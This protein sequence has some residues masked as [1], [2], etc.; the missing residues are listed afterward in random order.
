MRNRTP[1]ETLKGPDIWRRQPHETSLSYSYFRHYRDQGETRTLRRTAKELGRNET[2]VQDRARRWRWAQRADADDLHM[3]EVALA[4][5]REEVRS[6]S[7]R[8]ARLGLE[9]LSL[10]LARITG[11]DTRNIQA[12]DPNKLTPQDLAR[13]TEVMSKLERLSRGAES[14]RVEQTGQ[15]AQIRLAFN[16][17]PDLHGVKMDGFAGPS[18]D[19]L[20]PLSEN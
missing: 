6:M 9:T 12:I 18:L 7:Q 10:V 3:E 14:E 19:E 16:P 5:Q 13:L 17:V 11:D 2:L 8:H 15:P 20:P 1:C 4:A